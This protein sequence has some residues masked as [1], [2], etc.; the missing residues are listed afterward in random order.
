MDVVYAGDAQ[1]SITVC[2][3]RGGIN[4]VVLAGK[5]RCVLQPL[6]ARLPMVGG[7][8]GAFVKMPRFDFNLTGMG[9][10][11]QVRSFQTEH[12]L[13]YFIRRH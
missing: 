8:S 13:G 7:V 6:L 12:L 11:V 10:F 5:V 3:L 1:F 9:E 2:G 4:N